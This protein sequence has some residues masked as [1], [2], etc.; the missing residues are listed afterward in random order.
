VVVANVDLLIPVVAAASPEPNFRLL[1]RFLALAEIDRIEAAVVIN[2]V[3]LGVTPAVAQRLDVYTHIGYTVIRASVVTGEG[4]ADLRTLLTD[5]LSALVGPSGVGKSS[6]LNALEPGLALK[7]GAVSSSVGKGK[8]TTR[9]GEL[10]A[11]S[12]GGR[13]ADTPGLRELGLWDMDP[14]ELAW[15]FR[16]F[17]PHLERCRFDDCAH[18]IEP[19]CSV[20]AAVDSGG[21]DA[22]RYASFVRILSDEKA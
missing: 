4:L 14:T 16:E 13:V 8:H 2:K 17:R 10:H 9:V 15:A 20:R 21:I 3:D 6:L 12:F 18:T 1:D 5:R 19:G 11:L 22:D 7:V